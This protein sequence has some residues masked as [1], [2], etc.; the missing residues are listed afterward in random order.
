M[1]FYSKSLILSAALTLLA[2]HPR[3]GAEPATFATR[4][5]P[6]LEKNCTGCH[7]EDK[8]KGSLRLDTFAHVMRGSDDRVVVKAKDFAASE[9]HRR[10]T[11]PAS[12]EDVMPSDGKPLLSSADILLLEKWIA[13]GAP[14]TE[15][16]DAPALALT[17]IT[18]SAAP[19]Y[20]PRLAAAT[21]L[22]KKLGIRLVPRSIVPTDGLI[23][24]TASAP[25]QCNDAVLAQ[26]APFAD[27]IVEAELARTTITDAGLVSLALCPNLQIL[28]LTQTAV[29]AQGLGALHPLKNLVVLNLTNTAANQAT[30]A[31]LKKL[32]SLHHLWLFGTP[33]DPVSA[34][35]AAAKAK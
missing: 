21:A 33:A 4:V 27:L 24:R 20:R 34:K 32:P 35:P 8:Q 26:L 29:T 22:A 17:P 10:I 6:V 23:L 9:L 12:D 3:L 16:F 11:L 15:P 13:A 7:G 14:A 25:T 31:S 2:F 30:A 1:I 5:A 18:S 19:D 28:D